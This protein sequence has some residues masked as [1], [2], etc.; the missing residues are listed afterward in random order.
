M[1]RVA[2]L[3]YVRYSVII[4]Y[5]V[6]DIFFYF[7]H[8]RVN[9]HPSLANIPPRTYSDMCATAIPARFI[10]SELIAKTLVRRGPTIGRT[11]ITAEEFVSFSGT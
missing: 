11:G 5:L 1:L 2:L 7:A 10:F 4:R 3:R 6:Y 8:H 9:A